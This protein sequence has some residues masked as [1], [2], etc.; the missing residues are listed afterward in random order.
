MV[1]LK[2]LYTLFSPTCLF[3]SL[4]TDSTVYLKALGHLL[5][6]SKDRR[7]STRVL[8]GVMINK[9]SA[10]IPKEDGLPNAQFPGVG[11]CSLYV[12]MLPHMDSV[13]FSGSSLQQQK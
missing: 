8:L 3:K 6:G 9:I 1:F 5:P 11:I 2:V 13:M 7:S 4:T 10:W 12:L